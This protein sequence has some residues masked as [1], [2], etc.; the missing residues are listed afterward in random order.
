MEICIG[1]WRFE[2]YPD[3]EKRCS[4]IGTHSLLLFEFEMP[5]RGRGSLKSVTVKSGRRRDLHLRTYH[6]DDERGRS[7]LL[8]AAAPSLSRSRSSHVISISVR[9]E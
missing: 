1:V 5:R 7:A 4:G 8:C 3:A 9:G 2:V 6:T